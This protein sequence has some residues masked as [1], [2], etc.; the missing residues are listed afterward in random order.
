M[1]HK[2]HP[3]VNEDVLVVLLRDQFIDALDSIQLQGQMKQAKPVSLQE[4]R[5]PAPSLYCKKVGH[6][7]D[8]CYKKK[9]REQ[10]GTATKLSKRPKC[11]TRT[12]KGYWKECQ[13]KTDLKRECSPRAGN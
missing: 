1:A 9:K 2:T 8:E 6:K 4:A 5:P 13:R 3:E 10:N 7:K 11:W 12:E